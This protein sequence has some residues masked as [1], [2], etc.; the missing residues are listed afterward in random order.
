LLAAPARRALQRE[1]IESLEQLANYSEGEILELH[2][3]GPI[4]I[5]K[6][7]GALNEKGL[8]FRG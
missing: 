8:E 7:R 6:L 1:R 5:P 3:I 2:G 4:T